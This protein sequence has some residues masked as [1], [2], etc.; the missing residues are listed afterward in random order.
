M[1]LVLIRSASSSAHSILNKTCWY[2]LEAPRGMNTC[3]RGDSNEYLQV[4]YWEIRKKK[5]VV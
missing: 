4:F 3:P 5:I 1:L 2:S